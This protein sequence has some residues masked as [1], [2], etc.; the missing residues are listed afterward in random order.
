[1]KS[2]LSCSRGRVNRNRSNSKRLRVSP[3]FAWAGAAEEIFLF[4][5]ELNGGQSQFGVYGQ[6]LDAA[7]VRQ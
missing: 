6:K 7:G 4:W 5:T 2:R 3:A 1:M